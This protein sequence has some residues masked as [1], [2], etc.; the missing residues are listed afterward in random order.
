MHYTD[1][2][3]VP[4]TVPEPRLPHRGRLCCSI[5]SPK[6]Y[7]IVILVCVVGNLGDLDLAGDSSAVSS[8]T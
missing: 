1:Q 5:V 3:S 8:G 4:I 6:T 7:D 2:S